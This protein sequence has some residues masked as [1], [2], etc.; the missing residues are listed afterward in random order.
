MWGCQASPGESRVCKIRQAEILL[1][2]TYIKSTHFDN[3]FRL[4]R[5]F[6]FFCYSLFISKFVKFLLSFFEFVTEFLNTEFVG[7]RGR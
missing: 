6:P 3:N 4:R 1:S 2:F 7:D 5:A